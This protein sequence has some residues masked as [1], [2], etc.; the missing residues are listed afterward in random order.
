[1]FQLLFILVLS[2][3]VVI[4]ILLFQTPLRKLL[5]MALDKVKQGRGPVMAK[6]VAVTLSAVFI[7]S[8]YSIIK[9]QKRSMDGGIVNPTDQVLLAN[10][11]LEASLMGTFLFLAVM[12]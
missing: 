9:I 3:M 12:N 11:I 4:S 1:M 2:E 8:L 6:T 7:S 10:H 5:V